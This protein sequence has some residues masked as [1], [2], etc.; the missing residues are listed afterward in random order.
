MIEHKLFPTL[1]TEHLYSD[2]VDFKKKFAKHIFKHMTPEGYS[3][4]LTNHVTLHHEK[5]FEPLFKFATEAAKKHCER[6]HIDTEKFDFNIIKTWMNIKK[7]AETPKHMHGDAHIS[8]S[9]YVNMPPNFAWPIRFYNY[10]NRHEPYPGSIVHNNTSNIWDE[11][12]SGSWQFVPS[13]GS[14]FVFPSNLVHDTVG[15]TSWNILEQGVTKQSLMDYRHCLAG[16]I[17]MTYKKKTPS[18]LGV[19]PVSNWRNFG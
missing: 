7:S 16:D 4:E 5:S 12:N 6:L 15:N 2:H 14:L 1:V 19:Q 8:F 18:H 10:D 13:E 11:L 3:S 9:Y 17:L